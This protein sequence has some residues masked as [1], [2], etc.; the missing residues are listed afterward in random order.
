MKTV[1]I[2]DLICMY[3]EPIANDLLGRYRSAA[4]V[5]LIDTSPTL[6]IQ[7]KFLGTEL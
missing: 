5:N 7:Q 2:I 6:D 1:F 4:R 3:S